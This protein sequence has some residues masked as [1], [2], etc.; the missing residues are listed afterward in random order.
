MQGPPIPD[1]PLSRHL[2]TLLIR[3]ALFRRDIYAVRHFPKLVFTF[4]GLNL[5]GA[6][7]CSVLLCEAQSESLCNVHELWFA[8]GYLSL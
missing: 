1:S 3:I 5:S 6:T 7:Y 4:A 2:S 8:S